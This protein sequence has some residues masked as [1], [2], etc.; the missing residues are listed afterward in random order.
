MIPLPLYKTSGSS[1]QKAQWKLIDPGALS[2][3]SV[4]SWGVR[5]LKGIVIGTD[6]E[7][8]PKMQVQELV[9]VENLQVR[10]FSSKVLPTILSALTPSTIQE[11]A[12]LVVKKATGNS[13]SPLDLIYSKE[14]F[15][16]E[17]A[18]IL[19]DAT[20]LSDSDFDVLL[21]Y[22]SRDSN[23]IAYDGKVCTCYIHFEIDFNSANWYPK[24][25]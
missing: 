10:A 20:E 17:F 21:I 7:T 11:A 19:H 2:P 18:S 12:E 15:V 13:A 25:L 4:M 22:L 9:L 8:A 16:E 5:Q 14:S 6:G 3:W 23:A 24:R 1:L